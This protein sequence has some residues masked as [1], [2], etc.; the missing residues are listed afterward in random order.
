MTSTNDLD[1]LLDEPFPALIA[2]AHRHAEARREGQLAPLR[3]R[4]RVALLSG[5]TTQP[6]ARLFDLFL[7][8]AGVEAELYEAPYGS[9]VE[10]VLN[11]GSGL[12]AFAP[13]LTVVLPHVRDI[14]ARPALL[15][16][17]A[18]SAALVAHEAE[19]WASYWA[20]LGERTRGQIVHATFA[21][22]AQRPQGNLAASLPG[23]ELAFVRA[24]NAALCAR[25]APSVT[26]FDL[27]YLTGHFG[28]SRAFDARH[29]YLSKQDFSF[30]FMPV[31]CHAL[32][33]QI[34]MQAGLSR[35]C[36]VLDLDGTLWGG[37]VGEDGVEGIVL[38]PDSAEGEAFRD[39]QCYLGQLKERGV[40]LAVC[41]KNDDANARAPF[42]SHPHMA[43][44][45]DDIACFVANW[46]D[47][48]TNVAAIAQALNIGLDALV[49]VD[50]SPEER[51]MVRSALPDVAVLELPEDPA[52]YATALDRAAYFE[53]GEVTLEATQRT[54]YFVGDEQRRG[55]QAAFV[56]YQAY[57]QSLALCAEVKPIDVADLGRVAELVKRTN[58]WNLRTMR[59]GEAELGRL[60]SDPSNVCFSVSLSDRFG[61]YGTIGV[62][63]L[64]RDGDALFIDTWLMSCR[65][66]NKGVEQLVLG[67]MLRE[68]R[69]RGVGR[70]VGEYRPS[71]KNGM[72]RELFPSLGFWRLD[73]SEE[74]VV[75]A[76]DVATAAIPAHF[77]TEQG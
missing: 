59:H 35:K 6:L 16:S 74:R 18:E 14:E 52:D 9:L 25:R 12:Y 27:D 11:P 62:A 56:D 45:L 8:R 46:S 2:Q 44:R 51:H 17:P 4:R 68:A 71:A 70:L 1:A 57:L 24:L 41:S 64:V 77:I 60:A 47:K 69:A 66:L 23:S 34:A 30:A 39:F 21:L 28:L 65:V 37:M 75:Y 61:P 33:R 73:A 19:R 26:L 38:G 55:T 67:R 10:S 15:A 76:L 58:Q 13:Q 5:S 7:Y 43:L 49:F 29:Y 36:A 53:I 31:L 63:L 50:N 48:A 32:A 72:V 40:L 54:Q 22:P 42:Q 20:L 3:V